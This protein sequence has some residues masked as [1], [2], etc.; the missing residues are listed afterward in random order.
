MWDAC[1][2]F[3]GKG[4]EV[5]SLL[6][7]IK[8]DKGGNLLMHDQLR[9]LGRE[10]IRLENQ[11]EPQNR[12][13]LWTYEEAA[14]VLGSN[15]VAPVEELFLRFYSGQFLSEA[16]SCARSVVQR[17]FGGL[18]RMGST[19]VHLKRPRIPPANNSDMSYRTADSE[20][21]LKRSRPFAISEENNE[22]MADVKHRIADESGN[23]SWI[24]KLTEINEPWQ[25]RSLRLPDNTTAA[26]VSRLT[27]TNSGCAILALTSN[28]EHKLWKWQQ[29]DGNSTV[30]ATTSVVP[31]LWRPPGGN[32]L[33]NDT[34]NTNPEE[35]VP[36]FALSK[37][38]CYLISTSGGKI[39]LF[40]I[41]NFKTMHTFMP[42]SPASIFL[43]TNPPDNDIITIGMEDSTIQIYSGQVDEV[44]TKLKGRQR[45]IKGF[46]FSTVLNVLWSSSADSQMM[47]TFMPPPPAAPFVPPPPAATFLAF[48]PQDNNVIAIGMEDS[49]ILIYNVRVG[50]VKKKLEGHEK[51]ITG[52]AFSNV[53]NILV[54]SGADSQLCAWS[55]DGWEKQ[56]SRFL[57]MPTGRVAAPLAD[58]RVQF[59]VDQIRLLVVQEKQVAIYEAPK[60]ECLQQ[61]VTREASGPIT[62]ATYSCNGRSIY[63]SF[64]DGSIGVLTASALSLRCRINPAAY[65]PPNPSL[66]V[67]PLAIAAHPFEPNQFAL[68][69]TDGSV[70]VLEPLESE[71][72]WSSSPPVENGAG[73]STSSVATSSDQPHLPTA[74]EAGH[75]QI[76]ARRLRPR[77]PPPCD[78]GTEV[79]ERL[80]KGRNSRQRQGS[81]GDLTGHS[82]KKKRRAHDLRSF[83]SHSRLIFKEERE[84]RVLHIRDGGTGR[85]LISV[86]K[87]K[88]PE[89]QDLVFLGILFSLVEQQHLLTL[90][91]FSFLSF[92]I[93]F[94]LFE[95]AVKH[96]I[97][98]D[99]KSVISQALMACLMT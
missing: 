68:G 77:L 55:I 52:L 24:R 1:G 19:Q 88:G 30:R 81:S 14:E 96:Y 56:A 31:Q 29:S 74:G 11:K 42:P 57:Q 79:L 21:V 45:I 61:W 76:W 40:N 20:H 80:S 71:G 35:A 4:I 41:V 33:T 97:I 73:S 95:D 9:D 78:L 93:K 5:L 99:R 86:S 90:S 34:R 85:D 98:R 28:A 51:R 65:I 38:D 6:S 32:L 25:C 8:I 39:S 54:S 69:L 23:K 60:L 16:I 87:L 59:H 72:E 63:V 17:D 22:S 15:K 43:A 2:F 89:E 44:Q 49:S 47:T 48:H 94:H 46:N 53:L 12:S 64:K 7:L 50:E 10:I 66:R 84:I 62:D 37:N 18:G 91:R 58:T 92:G 67:Y 70:Y 27:Y 36:C 3:P 26:R 75:A 13:R 83:D 82:K